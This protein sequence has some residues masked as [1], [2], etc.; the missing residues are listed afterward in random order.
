MLY[1]KLEEDPGLMAVIYSME[2]ALSCILFQLDQTRDI[3]V[4]SS[5]EN[6]C[7][8]TLPVKDI[9]VLS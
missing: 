6:L 2:H 8:I 5:M 9:V 4:E 7:T 3:A 1:V